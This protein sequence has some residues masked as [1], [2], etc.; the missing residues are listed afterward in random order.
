MYRGSDLVA[1]LPGSTLTLDVTGLAPST[2]YTFTVKA[3]DQLGRPSVGD[4]TTTTTTLTLQGGVGVAATTVTE[5]VQSGVLPPT[6]ANSL[7]SKLDA[8]TSSMIKG[9]NNAAKNQLQLFVQQVQALERSGRLPLAEGSQLID[10][11]N[12]LMALL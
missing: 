10:Q 1:N 3:Q 7:T 2:S 12:V 5:F 6:A 4:L 9:N 8:A 11:A